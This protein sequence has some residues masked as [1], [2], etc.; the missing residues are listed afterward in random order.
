MNEEKKLRIYQLMESIENDE[1][2]RTQFVSWFQ[3]MAWY[4]DV[5]MPFSEGQ[6][7]EIIQF[8]ESIK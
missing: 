4:I 2:K 5:G 1:S 8:L 3:K 6:L 7:D